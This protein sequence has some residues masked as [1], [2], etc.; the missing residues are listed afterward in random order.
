MR[1]L[2][3]AMTAVTLLAGTGTLYGDGYNTAVDVVVKKSFTDL[4]GRACTYVLVDEGEEGTTYRE[5]D[6]RNIDCDYP[7]SSS[8]IGG[9]R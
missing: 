6:V 7:P 9:K 3:M 1:S 8:P 5:I 4:H 2:R